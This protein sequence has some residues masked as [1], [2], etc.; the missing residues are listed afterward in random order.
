MEK[1]QHSFEE[2]QQEV[3]HVTQQVETKT[4]Y[5]LELERTPAQFCAIA[6]IL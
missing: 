6:A 5:V 2:K 3:V 1:L 4:E